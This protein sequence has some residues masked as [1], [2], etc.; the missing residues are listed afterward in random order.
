MCG[1]C[2]SPTIIPAAGGAVGNQV[3]KFLL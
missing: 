1:I 3:L 2:Y